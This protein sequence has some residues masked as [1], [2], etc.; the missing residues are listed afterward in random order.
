LALDCEPGLRP[1]THPAGETCIPENP[2]HIVT[3]QDQNGLLPLPELGVTPVR[4]AG[5]VLEDGSQVFRRTEG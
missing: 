5:H 3:L 1:F 2:Q 4:S